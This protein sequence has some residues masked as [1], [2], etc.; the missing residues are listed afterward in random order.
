MRSGTKR[1]LDEL[2][3]LVLPVV[4]P[5]V[6]R[7]PW[8]VI[9]IATMASVL[10]ALVLVGAAR[11]DALI[12]EHSAITTAEVLEG[13]GFS[14]TLVRFTT[15][16]GQAVVPEFGVFYPGGLQPGSFVRVEYDTTDSDRVRVFG[17]TASL[18]VLPILFGATVV[19]VLALPLAWWL[20][21]RQARRLLSRVQRVG[22]A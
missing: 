9:G 1:L 17:R 2:A 12:S 8:V 22:S 19:W 3:A 13:S 16:D 6:R 18:G 7:L 10:G 4:M 11:D 5:V 20:R 14:R 21:R 15:Q